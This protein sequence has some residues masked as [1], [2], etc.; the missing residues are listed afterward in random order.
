MRGARL[1]WG[2][3]AQAPGFPRPGSGGV[4]RPGSPLRARPSVLPGPPPPGWP[5]SVDSPKR[6]PPP[7]G[8]LFPR[9]SPADPPLSQ[10]ETPQLPAATSGLMGTEP[11]HSRFSCLVRRPGRR[12]RGQLSGSGAWADVLMKNLQGIIRGA[13]SSPCGQIPTPSAPPP[14][15]GLLLRPL[16][17]YWKMPHDFEEIWLREANAWC[18]MRRAGLLRLGCKCSSGEIDEVSVNLRLT[19]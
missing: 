19:V 14:P 8:L 15:P 5:P 1:G 7:A 6:H 11:N 3:R 4:C 13:C 12:E 16:Q 2:V 10:P 18:L 9:P 17:E